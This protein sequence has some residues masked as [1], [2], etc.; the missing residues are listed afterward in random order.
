MKSRC[1]RVYHVEEVHW[2]NDCNI[3]G[4]VVEE[5]LVE[6]FRLLGSFV[7]VFCIHRKPTRIIYRET[8]RL[9]SL[10]QPDREL[11][12]RR[13][14]WFIVL[15]ISMALGFIGLAIL[16]FLT[17]DSDCILSAVDAA[18]SEGVEITYGS[19]I[20]LMHEKTKF[21]L[22]S[23]DVPY[24]S[25]SGQQSVTGFPNVNDANSYWIVRP[26]TKT[27][28]QP[29]EKIKSGTIIRL[30]HMKTRKWLHSHLHAS[31][32]SGNLEVSC[33][34]DDGNSDTGDYWRLEIEGSGKTWRQD[35]RIR[36]RHVDT[37]GYLHSHDKKYN[38]IAGG[39]QEVC[40]VR[41]KRADNVWLAAE[42]IYLP[43]TETKASMTK[44]VKSAHGDASV[45]SAPLKRHI[46]PIGPGP[47][48]G[49]KSG[50]KPDCHSVTGHIHHIFTHVHPW[51]RTHKIIWVKTPSKSRCNRPIYTIQT[52]NLLHT[53]TTIIQ[54]FDQLVTVA[55]P[56]NS[57]AVQTTHST[58]I[59]ALIGYISFE[60]SS[61][62]P[63]ILIFGLVLLEDIGKSSINCQVL[64]KET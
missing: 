29:G 14:N 36:L 56:E 31:P 40:G 9:S 17:L 37:S 59:A 55:S 27:S 62:A 44:I 64:A 39:Q 13:R 1:R 18:N 30:Q 57:E 25:G 7:T 53:R 49:P 20:K 43:T 51:Q 2:L 22:H 50:H 46:M 21:R 24:G 15:Q 11:L 54:A 5:F 26:E 47:D 38:R 23:H 4:T 33:F 61:T 58:H 6:S 52:S 41:E 12:I 16:L 63:Q 19:V 35:Q 10:F 48:P 32:I 60:L 45:R 28:Y 42:G 3:R 34:G 8:L